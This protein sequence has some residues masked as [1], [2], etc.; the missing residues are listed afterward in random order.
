MRP[1]DPTLWAETHVPSGQGLDVHPN[2]A[3]APPVMQLPASLPEGTLSSA[4][5]ELE[6][7]KNKGLLTKAEH[8]EAKRLVLLQRIRPIQSEAERSMF[9]SPTNLHPIL[10]ESEQAEAKRHVLQ[11]HIQA[12][13]YSAMAPHSM[14]ASL[15]HLQHA[16]LSEQAEAK[17]HVLQQHFCPVQS[18]ADSHSL[19]VAP[20]MLP[21]LPVL[22]VLGPAIVSPTNLRPTP[23]V[24]RDQL[25]LVM[26]ASIAARQAHTRIYRSST[27]QNISE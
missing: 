1:I 20:P 8:A 11:Q 12:D 27:G 17:R 25:C 9:V 15:S 24:R 2:A 4:L 21:V 26:L 14:F 5:G 18:E 13:S 6:D 22:P 10:S 7:A 19:P 3:S 23:R 16:I